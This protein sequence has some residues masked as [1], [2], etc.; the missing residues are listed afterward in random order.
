MKVQSASS[1]IVALALAAVMPGAVS[2]EIT[3][4]RP[5]SLRCVEE[6]STGFNWVNK[7]WVQ[8][9]FKPSSYILS[10]L[11]PTSEP[12]ED[13]QNELSPSI[14][15]HTSM[16]TTGCYMLKQVGEKDSLGDVCRESWMEKNGWL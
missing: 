2:A 14:E 4:S 16:K 10:K 7:E 13:F 11:E 1:F 8:T 12:C 9:N 5:F 3:D 6:K 15:R